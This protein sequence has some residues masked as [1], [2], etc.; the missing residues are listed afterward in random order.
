MSLMNHLIGTAEAAQRLRK[1]RATIN[2]MV[3][4]GEIRPFGTIG[5]KRIRVFELEEIERLA[6]EEV[7]A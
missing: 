3:E 5:P 2:R 6:S 7:R 4:S 1:S